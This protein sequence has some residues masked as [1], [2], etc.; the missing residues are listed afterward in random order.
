VPSL[1]WRREWTADGSPTLVHPVH[2]E[3]CHNRVGAW[4]ESQERY[5]RACGLPEF[6]AAG[7]QRPLRLLDVGT[8]LGM[9]LS[10]AL[11]AAETAGG[12]LHAVSFESDTSVLDE[13]ARWCAEGEVRG[14]SARWWPLV[15]AALTEARGNPGEWV[16]LAG[17]HRLQLCLG[18]ASE[19]LFTLADT[20]FFDACFFDPF[21]AS[22]DDSLWGAPFLMEC[23]RRLASGGRLSTYSE[24]ADARLAWTAAGLHV[25]EGAPL[26]EKRAGSLALRVADTTESVRP[27]PSAKLTALLLRRLPQW[28][29]ER[30]LG[31]P[32]GWPIG[33]PK[34][35]LTGS[36]DGPGALE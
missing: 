1:A 20:L 3:A 26:G 17:R 32:A 12:V 31:L 30:G 4:L 14:P 33:A 36:K 6:F 21:S 25:A 19:Q 23:A 28:C 11:C 27:Q 13:A 15:Q 34:N 7:T 24:R 16:S 18:D 10:A 35:G 8:G 9:N 22:A 2:G 29:A 5:V